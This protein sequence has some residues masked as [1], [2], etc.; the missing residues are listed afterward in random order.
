MTDTAD[1]KNRK[2]KI[3][4]AVKTAIFLIFLFFI[5]FVTI[6]NILGA[7]VKRG[8]FYEAIINY[9][10]DNK[11]DTININDYR[12]VEDEVT[13]KYILV[14]TDKNNRKYTYRYSFDKKTIRKSERL[15]AGWTLV[16]DIDYYYDPKS[17]IEKYNLQKIVY[18]YNIFGLNVDIR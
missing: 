4:K 13:G 7:N 15:D 8:I 2:S 11:E 5:V 6:I 9:N 3:K 10:I 14:Q 1:K 16:E 18:L 12:M 17:Y